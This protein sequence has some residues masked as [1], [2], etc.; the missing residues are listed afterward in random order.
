LE[1][2]THETPVLFRISRAP[3]KY[4]D[5]VTAV[6]PC[7]PADYAGLYTTCFSVIGGHGSCSHDWLRTTRPATPAEYAET[8]RVLLSYD[9]KVYKR[10]TTKHRQTFNETVR[11]MIL[12]R[13]C[14]A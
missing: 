14:S 6:L 3:K 12:A 9:V 10:T 2:D 5:E 4:G 11:D 1:K 8:L 13:K 7:E